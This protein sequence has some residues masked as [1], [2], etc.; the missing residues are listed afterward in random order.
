MPKFF[1]AWLDKSLPTCIFSAAQLRTFKLPELQSSPWY[2]ECAKNYAPSEEEDEK[3]KALTAAGHLPRELED[4]E[5]VQDDVDAPTST[6]VV[7]KKGRGKAK[8]SP[9]EASGSKRQPKGKATKEAAAPSQT[10]PPAPSIDVA[11]SNR[12]MNQPSVTSV[13]H[14]L[15]KSSQ[16]LAQT[17]LRPQNHEIRSQ[18]LIMCDSVSLIMDAK[19]K[20]STHP[21]TLLEIMEFT[22]KVYI[23]LQIF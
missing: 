3:T 22:K 1:G 2:L 20:T 19:L 10:Q 14:E 16:L 11:Q 6:A 9:T 7:A 18:V 23:H 5:E 15:P 13:S 12:S 17:A 4:E 8:T 21:Q